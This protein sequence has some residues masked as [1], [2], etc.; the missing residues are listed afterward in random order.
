MHIWE[1]R[2]SDSCGDGTR[3]TDSF[4]AKQG[5]TSDLDDPDILLQCAICRDTHYVLLLELAPR[6]LDSVPQAHAFTM[7]RLWG[8]R[9]S[10]RLP[11]AARAP[12]LS[13]V[14]F[15]APAPCGSFGP[16]P[17]LE[18]HIY[19]NISRVGVSSTRQR[20]GPLRYYI[21]GGRSSVDGL[22]QPITLRP[23]RRRLD[24]SG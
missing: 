2:K 7:A 24:H 14:H 22:L 15:N 6:V 1:V 18:G 10:G 8:W 9:G 11:L 17:R 19:S 12:A 16:R 5:D 13:R 4:N 20:Q 23:A 3:S 21:Q